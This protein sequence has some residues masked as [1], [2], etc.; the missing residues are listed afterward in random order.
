LFT[1]SSPTKTV[2]SL[3]LG[4]PVVVTPV[5]DQAAL[6][7]RTGGGVVAP[8]SADA[9]ADAVAGLLDDPA[10]AERMGS[11]ARAAVLEFRSYDRLADELQSRLE[12]LVRPDEGSR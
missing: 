9:F 8:F 5:G 6:V 2:E 12:R 10:R 1:D 3:A 7:E 11:Q 4:T